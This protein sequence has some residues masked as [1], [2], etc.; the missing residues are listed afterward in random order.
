M[1]PYVQE[2]REH[3]GVRLLSPIGGVSK[4]VYMFIPISMVIVHVH[5]DHGVERFIAPLDEVALAIMSHKQ[6]RRWTRRKSESI[7]DVNES[8]RAREELP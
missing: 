2:S 7:L 3:L 1:S 4:T 5:G 8:I 6:R